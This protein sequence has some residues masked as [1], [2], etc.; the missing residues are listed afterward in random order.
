[1]NDPNLTAEECDALI[2]LILKTPCR[3]TDKYSDD[4]KVN[5]RTIRK[6]LGHLADIQDGIDQYRVTPYGTVD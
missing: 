4:F 6:K 3:L 2:Q 1:M 5:F